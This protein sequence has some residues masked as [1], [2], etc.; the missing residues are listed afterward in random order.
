MRKSPMETDT[1]IRLGISSCLLGEQVRYDGQ[2]KLDRFLRDTLGQY[3]EYVPVCPEFECGLGIPREAMRLVGDPEH[4]RLMTR[5]TGRDFTEKMEAYAEQRVHELANEGL[6]GFIFKSKSPSSG[7]ER[8]KVY[9]EKGMPYSNEGVGIFARIFMD[10]FPL[11]PVEDDGRLHD[12]GLRENFIE[13]IFLFKRWQDTVETDQ[14][15]AS[16]VDFHT[17]HK[18]LIMAHSPKAQTELGKLVAEAGTDDI[19]FGKLKQE[20]LK[21]LLPALKQ[22][23]GNRKNTNVLDHAMGYFKKDLTADEKNELREIIDSYHSGFIPLIVPI[24]L[25]NHY[26]RKYDKKYLA[27]QYFFYPHPTELKLRNHS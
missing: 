10:N 1:T 27:D 12:I 13:R 25:L 3:V 14:T 9:T 23:A 18:L 26:I 22:Q 8:I 5:K 7:M 21:I 16:L 6:C 20:Y 2:H 19:A 24:T 11:L 15:A 17:R 4:P